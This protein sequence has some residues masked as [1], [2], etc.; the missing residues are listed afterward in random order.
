MGHYIQ[1]EQHRSGSLWTW[2]A[3]KPTT[4]SHRL[5]QASKLCTWALV[6]DGFA[7]AIGLAVGLIP[8]SVIILG[9]F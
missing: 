7:C 9:R 1:F 3:T 6:V 2:K 5:R 8:A 4:R